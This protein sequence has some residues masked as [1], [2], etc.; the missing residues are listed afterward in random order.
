MNRT[1]LRRTITCGLLLVVASGA[2]Y[3]E[4]QKGHYQSGNLGT[5]PQAQPAE[6]SVDAKY[7]AGAYASVPPLLPTGEGQV[8][9][10]GYCSVCHST[11]YITMQPP[12]PAT[13][14]EA[15]VNKMIH[16]Y[17]AP[18][19]EASAKKIIFYLQHNFTPESRKQ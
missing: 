12:L 18:V 3:A 14:W 9:T 4:L 13:A 6:F 10:V 1:I 8:E 19:P 7:E 15:E 11:R 2:V 17:G 5:I 16:V